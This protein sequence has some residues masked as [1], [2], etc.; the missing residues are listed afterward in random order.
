MENVCEMQLGSILIE[1]A[2]GKCP[3]QLQDVNM[4]RCSKEMTQIAAYGLFNISPKGICTKEIRTS[5][6]FK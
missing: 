2:P 4:R 6:T 1:M 3:V 5:R